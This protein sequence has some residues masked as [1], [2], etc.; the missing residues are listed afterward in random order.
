MATDEYIMFM[1]CVL[2]LYCCF[3][4]CCAWCSHLAVV[5]LCCCF[6]FC[7]CWC[8][9]LA[10]VFLCCCFCLFFPLLVFAPCNSNTQTNSKAGP[11]GRYPTNHMLHKI[12][13]CTQ[14]VHLKSPKP[15][16]LKP[17]LPVWYTIASMSYSSRSTIGINY[18]NICIHIVAKVAL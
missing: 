18:I 5:F 11:T 16:Q 4:F 10:V 9:H 17:S 6:G 3:C 7:C 13:T 12:Q 2:C 1:C 14:N 8:S 15:K